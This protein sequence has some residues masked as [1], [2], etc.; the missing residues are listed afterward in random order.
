ML[1]RLAVAAIGAAVFWTAGFAQSGSQASPVIRPLV[2]VPDDP[3]LR[4]FRWRSIGPAG[5]AGRVDDIAVDEKNPS[6]FYIGFATSGI[7]KTSNNGTTFEPI[8]EAYG[9]SSIGDLA[10][11]PSDSRVLYAGTGEANNRQTSTAGDGVWKS[12]DAGA[13]FTHVGLDDTQSIARIVVHPT[14][15]D[16]AWVAAAGHLYGPSSQRGVFMTTDGGKSWSRTLFVNDDTG[17]TDLIIDP[18]NPQN[19]WAAMYE[20]RRSAWGY[21]GGGRRSGI[22]ASSDGGKTWKRLVESGL[23][24]GTMGRI[25]LDISRS[26][27]DVLYAQIEVALDREPRMPSDIAEAN[28]P[29][30]IR[31]GRAG[32]TAVARPNPQSNGIWKSIDKGRTWQFV[33]NQNQRP[34]YFSQIRVDPT[35]P[36]VVYVG[37][38]NAQKS[39]DG[40]RTFANIEAHKGHVDNHAIWIDPLNARHVMY[41]DDG[42][43]EVSWDGGA[44]WESLRLFAT[45]LAYHVSADMRRPYWVCTGMQDNGSWCGPSQTRTGEL[46][47]WNWIN[48]G[49]GDGFQNVI[50]PADPNVL[51]TESQNLGLQRYNL[52]TG[53]VTNIK[54]NPPIITR[55]GTTE[56]PTEAPPQAQAFGGGRSNVLNHPAG[57]RVPTV[58]QFNWNAP[59]RLS[60]FDPATIYAG[61]RQLFVSHDRGDTWTMS[62][63]VGKDI[64]TS[65]RTLLGRSYALPACHR[66]EA[67]GGSP[68]VASPGEPCILSRGDGYAA[69]EYGT[70]TEIAES[71]VERA[72][73]WLGTD[74]GNVQLSRDGGASFVEVGA[75][76]PNVNHEYYVS[77][78]EASWFD[79]ATAYVALDGHRHDDERPYVFKTTDFGATWTAIASN[80]PA[81]AHV[82]TIRQDPVN[83]RLLFAGTERGFYISMNDGGSWSAFMPNLPSGRVDE[84]LVHPREHDLILAT[85]S[86]SVWILDDISPLEEWRDDESAVLFAPRAA[87]LWKPDRRNIVD[88]PGDKFWVGDPAPRGTAISFALRQPVEDA[89]IAIADNATNQIAFAC[90]IDDASQLQPGLHRVQWPLVSN[91]QL[92]GAGRGRAGGTG[93][94]ATQDVL[95]CSAL[96]S[97]RAA[98]P[99]TGRAAASAIRPGTYKATLT[100]GGRAIG[101]RTFDVLEDTWLT[102][103]GS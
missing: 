8:F 10:I 53:Q 46:H 26:N 64:D 38:V 43:V 45:G 32:A 93:E 99:A 87:V 20:H 15:P 3:R 84:V 97:P 95:P 83:R 71:P 103:G 16:I 89:T 72:I 78:L 39:V 91:Q 102:V 1:R 62:G 13:H 19:L 68:R 56:G 5:Q 17:A 50:D 4:E 101:S 70:A 57:G 94:A 40:G 80:L 27:P 37:G 14:N 24:R 66:D 36:N 34:M 98:M 25:G 100:I 81:A 77:G 69:N 9:V 18:S 52:A 61:G 67:E 63:P 48:V 12:V 6:T 41:G 2:N 75:H 82:N 30:P 96:S 7:W 44:T 29:D 54:P 65:T 86:R 92:A 23:P 79:A 28:A 85:H 59:I 90:R 35:D 49:A 51:Y 31:G 60:H 76:I 21:V 47:A 11:A 88:A 42:G 55:Q 73:V 33:S 58:S 22:Y 74:D